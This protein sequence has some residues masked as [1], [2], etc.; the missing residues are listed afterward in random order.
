MAESKTISVNEFIKKK[1]IID[2]H[3]I[4]FLNRKFKNQTHT[5]SEWEKLLK[6]ENIK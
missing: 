4:N 5:I 3:V 2:K 1:S 6:K